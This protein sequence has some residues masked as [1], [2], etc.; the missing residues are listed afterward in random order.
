MDKNRINKFSIIV[1]LISLFIICNYCF[2]LGR[3]SVSIPE[4]KIDTIKVEVPIPYEVESEIKYIYIEKEDTN[5]ESTTIENK[6][7]IEISI[8]RIV[9]Q[10]DN[11]RAV[12][13]GPKIGEFKP[14]LEELDIYSKCEHITPKKK[15]PSISP[16][17]SM[18]GSNNALGIGGGISINNKI[19]IG[20]KY[21]QVGIQDALML[22][23]NIKF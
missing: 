21:V 8:E 10:D 23:V 6:D 4:P 5:E 3:K 2:S 14:T 11:Y 18:C 12:I 20:I 13:S 15:L 7:S 9:Y 19:D 16:Y 22:E 1:F 17:I